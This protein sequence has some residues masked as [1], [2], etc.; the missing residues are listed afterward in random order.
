[1]TRGRRALDLSLYLVVGTPL[2]A[3][4]SLQALVRDAIVGGVTVVQLRRKGEAARAFVEEARALRGVL[5]PLD[6]PLIVN[7]RVD[8]ALA[9]DADGVHVGQDDLRVADVRRLVGDRLYVGLSVTSVAEAHAVNPALVDYVGVG[10]VFETP[11]KP[12]A[13][14]ALGLQGV[15][16][17]YDVLRVPSVAIGGISPSNAADVV[18]AGVDGVAVISAICAAADPRGAAASLRA[19]V[20]TAGAPRRLEA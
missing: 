8:V 18:A 4:R 12:D 19:V 20:R 10:P 6:V 7:D 11:S 1:M 17:I 5:H 9:A 13:A 14:P 2:P 3:G 16:D 15:H